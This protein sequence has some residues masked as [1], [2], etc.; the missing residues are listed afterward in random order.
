MSEH[1]IAPAADS[2]FLEVISRVV[3]HVDEELTRGAVRIGGA[4]H[5]Y[6]A[7]H[8]LQAVVGFVDD[9]KRV[10]SRACPPVGCVEAGLDH[11][12]LDPVEG[13][14]VIEPSPDIPQE[15][16][17]AFRGSFPVEF[18]DDPALRGLYD[19]RGCHVGARSR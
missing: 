16:I 11:V 9:R 2:F 4:G 3:Q 12:R 10:G 6:C 5:G 1:G 18:H 7:T 8:V 15:I 13:E 14:T 19:D 17:H